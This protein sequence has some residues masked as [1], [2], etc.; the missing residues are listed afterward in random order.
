MRN[1]DV[2]VVH[3]YIKEWLNYIRYGGTSSANIEHALEE[4]V[5]CL[6]THKSYVAKRCVEWNAVIKHIV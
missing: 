5:A 3:L 2:D 6:M 1:L 4:R